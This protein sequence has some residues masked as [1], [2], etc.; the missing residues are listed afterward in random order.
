MRKK[1]LR[2]WGY[3]TG[4]ETCRVRAVAVLRGAMFG[5]TEENYEHRKKDSCYR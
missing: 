1:L 5:K 3:L 2:K 4:N